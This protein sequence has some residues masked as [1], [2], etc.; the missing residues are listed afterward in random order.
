MEVWANVEF[1][2]FHNNINN[3][4]WQNKINISVYLKHG[5]CANADYLGNDMSEHQGTEFIIG[6][7]KE[8]REYNRSRNMFSCEGDRDCISLNSK[9]HVY[10]C[11]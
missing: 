10:N 11:L 7:P 2:L 5:L 8:L 9:L 6:V 3:N 1:P 4:K